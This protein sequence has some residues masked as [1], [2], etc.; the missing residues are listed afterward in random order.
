MTECGEQQPPLPTLFLFD[1][2]QGVQLLGS[3][4]SQMSIDL[5]WDFLQP[6]HDKLSLTK[7][8]MGAVAVDDIRSIPAGRGFSVQYDGFIVNFAARLNTVVSMVAHR[9]AVTSDS[10]GV[11]HPAAVVTNGRAT[12]VDD[13]GACDASV[14]GNEQPTTGAGSGGVPEWQGQIWVASLTAVREGATAALRAAVTK[15]LREQQR[16]L[17]ARN[18]QVCWGWEGLGP[19][20][21]VSPFFYWSADWSLSFR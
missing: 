14:A 16:V 15:R 4:P 9:I 2:L 7:G 3:C 20:K 12:R 5:Q 6:L 19:G 13:E 21:G 17:G 11:T 18:N 1:Y 10:L 8:H